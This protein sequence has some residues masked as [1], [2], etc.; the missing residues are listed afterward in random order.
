MTKW[1]MRFACWMPQATNTDSEYVILIAFPRQQCFLES[2]SMLP[3]TYI[4][5]RVKVFFHLHQTISVVSSLQVLQKKD[6]V[7]M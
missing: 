5:C 3:Y 6:F 4:T 1:R 7:L 2:T